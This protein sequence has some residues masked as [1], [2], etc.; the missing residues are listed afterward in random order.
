MMII[1][2]KF[3]LTIM[4]VIIIIII[5]IIIILSL[6]KGQCQQVLLVSLY[7]GGPQVS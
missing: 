7:D 3:T 2:N 1:I 6:L 4:V 5:I